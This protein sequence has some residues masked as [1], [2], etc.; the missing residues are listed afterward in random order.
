MIVNAWTRESEDH[1]KTITL[2]LL[3]HKGKLGEGENEDHWFHRDHVFKLRKTIQEQIEGEYSVIQIDRIENKSGPLLP[4][5]ADN[6]A[7]GYVYSSF[8]KLSSG[9]RSTRNSKKNRDEEE[10]AVEH[11]VDEQGVIHL[12]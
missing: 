9:S 3:L 2:T 1:W 6:I 10:D 4:D 8:D 12:D 5:L 7:R 11:I